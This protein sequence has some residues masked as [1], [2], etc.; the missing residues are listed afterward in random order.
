M[1]VHGTASLSEDGRILTITTMRKKGTKSVPNTT[2]YLVEDSRPDR[3]V[4]SPAFSLTK[5]SLDVL[6]DGEEVFCPSWEGE[7]WHVAVNEYGPT[8]DCQ[9][10]TYS[11]SGQCKHVGAMLKLGL[12]DRR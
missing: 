5:G 7:V 6:D 2:Q 10:A 1:Q 4:A 8:C 3:R 9:H 12:L 11:G